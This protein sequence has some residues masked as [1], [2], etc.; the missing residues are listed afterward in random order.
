MTLSYRGISKD[1]QD[2]LQRS[3]ENVLIFERLVYRES[4]RHVETLA[5]MQARV[6]HQALSIDLIAT[7]RRGC[8]RAHPL[9]WLC[10]ESRIIVDKAV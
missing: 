5:I 4:V 9:S 10:F 2:V 7:R 8:S 1:R 6:Q 3:E